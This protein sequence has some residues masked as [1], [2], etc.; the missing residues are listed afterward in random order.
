MEYLLFVKSLRNFVIELETS[1]IKTAYIFTTQR[2]ESN[3]N[4]KAFVCVLSGLNEN[5]IVVQL[6]VKVE[7]LQ[8]HDKLAIEKAMQH[9][10][11]KADEVKRH[12]EK[13][14][15]TVKEGILTTSNL[16]NY[17]MFD[18]IE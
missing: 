11:D 12:L 6:N 8:T 2:V 1:K 17:G 16:V 18:D 5:G 14:G 4:I 7:R 15:L 3:K 10:K 13:K 9:T